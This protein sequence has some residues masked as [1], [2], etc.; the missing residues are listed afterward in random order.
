MINYHTRPYTV[1]CSLCSEDI[2][3]GKLFQFDDNLDAQN[4]TMCLPCVEEIEDHYA[5]EDGDFLRKCALEA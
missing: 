2:E 5:Q 4:N 1:I 3:P